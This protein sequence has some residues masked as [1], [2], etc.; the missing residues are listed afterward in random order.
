MKITPKFGVIFCDGYRRTKGRNLGLLWF[1]RGRAALKIICRHL[2]IYHCSQQT[3]IFI[4][5]RSGWVTSVFVKGFIYQK[6]DQIFL[7]SLEELRDV[8]MSYLW[9]GNMIDAPIKKSVF[10]PNSHNMCAGSGFGF[11]FVLFGFFLNFNFFVQKRSSYCQYWSLLCLL[12]IPWQP[13]STV[14][15][16]N[17]TL[18]N[19]GNL[20]C[21]YMCRI[22]V[23]LGC[24]V[25]KRN[26]DYVPANRSED[27]E[28]LLCWKEAQ[29][30]YGEMLQSDLS[31]LK[32]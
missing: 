10:L 21:I 13:L 27:C 31:F 25:E 7:L 22:S 15:S 26:Q 2:V 8:N 18:Q 9:K 11:L 14:T 29:G 30:S 23:K 6:V 32:H 20:S 1:H 24:W 28:L 3:Q 19:G 16:V 4:V 12:H 17:H 5:L